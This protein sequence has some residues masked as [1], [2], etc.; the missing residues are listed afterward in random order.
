[1][2]EQSSEASLL[3]FDRAKWL[4][5]LALFAAAIYG[6]VQYAEQVTLLYRVAG[7]GLLM[8]L[9]LAVLTATDFGKASVKLLKRAYRQIP[10]V[11][12]PTRQ[13]TTQT[14]LIVV[15][16]VI[17]VGLMLWGVDSFIGWLLSLLLA[18]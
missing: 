11:T 5:A 7:V 12:W 2:T 4:V 14:T 10:E 13:E 3:W 16:V 9:G 1:M 18:S 6:N 15:V 17:L 8:V